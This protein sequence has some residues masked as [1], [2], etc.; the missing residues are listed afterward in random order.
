MIFRGRVRK[1]IVCN[2]FK[3]SAKNST[4]EPTFSYH[5]RVGLASV[6]DV[7]TE[8]SDEKSDAFEQRKPML[9]LEEAEHGVG[10]LERVVPIV[11]WDLTV[12]FAY[13]RCNKRD[14]SRILI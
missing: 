9:S 6:V 11:I 4:L 14:Y 1:I 5:V 2:T 13:L 7:V 10:D 12:V 3:L 8:T